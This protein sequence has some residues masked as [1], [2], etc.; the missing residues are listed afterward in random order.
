MKLKQSTEA[1]GLNINRFN[2]GTVTLLM[3]LE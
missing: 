2:G 3:M 1:W